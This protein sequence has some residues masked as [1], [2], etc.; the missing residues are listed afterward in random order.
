MLFLIGPLKYF[1]VSL[2]NV[3]LIIYNT[4][5]YFINIIINIQLLVFVL[6]FLFNFFGE[7]KI[8]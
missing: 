3:C 8:V 1:S 5:N 6:L 7:A 4:H 2:T